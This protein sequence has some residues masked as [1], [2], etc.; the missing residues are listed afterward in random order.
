MTQFL[1]YREGNYW[2]CDKDIT[3]TLE[4]AYLKLTD[5]QYDEKAIN[6]VL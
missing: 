2:K 6:F 4:D 3:K 1:Q 5:E